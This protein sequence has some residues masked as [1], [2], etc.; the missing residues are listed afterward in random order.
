MNEKNDGRKTYQR[1]LAILLIS[2]MA[3]TMPSLFSGETSAADAGAPY[4][5]SGLT[6][7][8]DYGKIAL[9]WDAPYGDIAADYYIIYRNYWYD[10]TPIGS[11]SDTLFVDTSVTNGQEYTYWV[12]AVNQNNESELSSMATAR[13]GSVPLMPYDIYGYG[14]DERTYIDWSTPDNGGFYI[15][16]YNVYRSEAGSDY[17]LLTSTGES[18]Y[19]DYGL[20]NGVE[21]RY[22]VAAV[23]E[24]GEGARSESVSLTPMTVPSITGGLRVYYSDASGYLVWNEPQDDGGSDIIEYRIQCQVLN[25]VWTIDTGSAVTE[26]WVEDLVNGY[27]YEFAVAAVNAV[28]QGQYSLSVSCD[29]FTVPT[30]VTNLKAFAG[31]ENVVLTWNLP[32]YDGG[33]EIT[34]FAIYRSTSADGGYS[35]IGMTNTTAYVDF[36]VEGGTT[37]YYRVASGNPIGLGEMSD[38]VSAEPSDPPVPWVAV[39]VI[40]AFLAVVVVGAVLQWRKKN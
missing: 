9:E 28:G 33:S 10:P 37:Y 23:N 14:Y 13:A 36:E 38:Q 20:T 22:Q 17:Y 30:P 6:A 7:V 40:I 26:Y 15:Y 4:P 19:N 5:P 2:C 35:L 29:V 18:Y 24:L 12:T 1:I 8:G 34:H 3:L 25:R 31:E 32:G 27:T 16:Y 21:Y 39:I 11:T